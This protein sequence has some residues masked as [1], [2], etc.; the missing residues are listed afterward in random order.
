MLLRVPTQALRGTLGRDIDVLNT[1]HVIYIETGLRHCRLC[2]TGNNWLD[3]NV[4]SETV[5]SPAKPFSSGFAV[6]SQP[7]PSRP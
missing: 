2:L 7:R 1:D 5:L 6:R 3:L 4:T